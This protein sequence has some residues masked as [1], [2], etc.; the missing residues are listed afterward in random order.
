MINT[1]YQY[2]C[3][4]E[5]TIFLR[6]GHV[7]W[8]EEYFSKKLIVILIRNKKLVPAFNFISLMFEWDG[9]KTQITEKYQN[10][11]FFFVDLV[12]EQGLVR[13]FLIASLTLEIS[14]SQ[15]AND[16][17]NLIKRAVVLEQIK[18]NN[19]LDFKFF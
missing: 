5:L 2:Q 16:L 7:N 12:I 4:D 6:S 9:A 1:F 14:F 19:K 18:P 3:Y 8:S 10:L 17:K 15:R 11:F 13:N